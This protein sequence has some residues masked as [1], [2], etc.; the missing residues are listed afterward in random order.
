[1]KIS[2]QLR[3]YNNYWQGKETVIGQYKYDIQYHPMAL[4]HTWIIRSEKDE[5]EWSF[6]IPLAEEIR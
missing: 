4:N 3:I 2:T 5:D 1:M 6:Y